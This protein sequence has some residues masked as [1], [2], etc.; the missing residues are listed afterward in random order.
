M[1]GYERILVVMLSSFLTIFLVLGIA[2]LILIIK[3]GRSVKR[4]TEKAEHLADQAENITE[5][6]ERA[7]AQLTIGRAI[8]GLAGLFTRVKKSKKRR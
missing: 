7:A 1:N 4:V 2:V 3:I 8:G 6:F 5:L